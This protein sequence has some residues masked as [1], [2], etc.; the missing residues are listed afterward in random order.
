MLIET[1]L[2]A[3]AVDDRDT[4]PAALGGPLDPRAEHGDHAAALQLR[5]DHRLTRIQNAMDALDE[6]ARRRRTQ[7]LL[8]A[9]ERL[10]A[11]LDETLDA[12]DAA[13]GT[14]AARREAHG[15][16]T[17]AAAEHPA[18]P[19]AADWAPIST[20]VVPIT[21]VVQAPAA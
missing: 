1:P 14:L 20:P 4:R 15:S 3:P 16:A 17:V 10:G 21:A 5:E 9:V 6:M 8:T 19:A 7:D 11:G 13:V 18:L 12:L 2:A